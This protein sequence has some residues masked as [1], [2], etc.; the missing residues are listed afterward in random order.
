MD[1]DDHGW[2]CALDNAAMGLPVRARVRDNA[3]RQHTTGHA[4]HDQREAGGQIRWSDVGFPIAIHSDGQERVHR[5]GSMDDTCRRNR[6]RSSRL[7]SGMLQPSMN[8]LRHPGAF[9]SAWLLCNL[10]TIWHQRT[11]NWNGGGIVE[12]DSVPLG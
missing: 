4:A 2:A 12:S 11:L 10:G 5:G 7:V 9:P 3:S 6:S 1:H 8:C